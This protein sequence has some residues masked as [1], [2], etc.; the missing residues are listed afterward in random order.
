MTYPALTTMSLLDRVPLD[1]LAQALDAVRPVIGTSSEL[2]VAALVIRH[3]VDDGAAE[4]DAAA[5]TGEFF[6]VARGTAQQL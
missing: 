5:I 3:L 2:A 1:E 6:G 4:E